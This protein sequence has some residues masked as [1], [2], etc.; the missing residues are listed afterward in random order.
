MLR[1]TRSIIKYL[2]VWFEDIKSVREC[3]KVFAIDRNDRWREIPGSQF[4][5]QISD[6]ASQGR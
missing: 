5:K 4:E 6:I 3:R 2:E 1:N